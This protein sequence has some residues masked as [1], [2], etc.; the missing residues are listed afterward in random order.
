VL[1]ASL[2]EYRLMNVT[3]TKHGPL[4]MVSGPAH[5]G[6][7]TLVLRLLH[8]LRRQ[9]RKPAGI[10]AEGHWQDHRRSGFTLVDLSDGRRTP[11]AD[12]IRD[13]GPNGFPYAFHPEGLA[14]GRR[15]LAL[16]RCAGA[17]LLVID[18]VGSLELR[19][20]GWADVLPPL[21]DRCRLPQ[22]WVVQSAWLEAVCK[23]WQ[24]HPIRVIDASTPHALDDLTASAQKLLADSSSPPLHGSST[25]TK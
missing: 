8:R 21:L 24:L 7:T 1:D 16:S 13:R 6:K 25:F 19:G 5:S 3:P 22:L 4:I 23:K 15:A 11:L 17:D 12:L 2:K 10:L 18:E 9:G 20:A 14:A